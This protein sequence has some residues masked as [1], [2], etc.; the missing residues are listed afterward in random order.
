MNIRD[1]KKCIDVCY[2]CVTACEH[3][4][5]ECLKEE[6][7][8]TLARCIALARECAIVCDAT[9]RLLSVGGENA[10]LVCRACYDMSMACAEECE[11]DSKELVYCAECAQ[12]CRR[13]AEE[14]RLIIEQQ[15]EVILNR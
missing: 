9:A 1:Y 15:A 8:S 2:A 12:A 10:T 14:C 13:C 3:C 11:S 6:D 4:A 5:T 7:T